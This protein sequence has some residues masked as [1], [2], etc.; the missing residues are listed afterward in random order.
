MLLGGFCLILYFDYQSGNTARPTL[1]F[2]QAVV[3]VEKRKK[4]LN[5]LSIYLPNELNQACQYF[6]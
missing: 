2:L 4:D 5:A 3:G 6:S 1:Q